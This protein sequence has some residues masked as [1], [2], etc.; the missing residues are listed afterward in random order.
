MN[1]EKEICITIET[2]AIGDI[3]TTVPYYGD[4]KD[5]K[6]I[7]KIPN[8]QFAGTDYTNLDLSLVV[9][10]DIE[11]FEKLNQRSDKNH[12]VY[13]DT[14]CIYGIKISGNYIRIQ[15][16]FHQDNNIKSHRM[17]AGVLTHCSERGN[18]LKPD[19]CVIPEC[20]SQDVC[21]YW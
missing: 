20:Y 21:V 7:L 8:R 9:E 3:I 5:N 13:I 11:N 19:I 1:K 6:F 16:W 12:Q 17:C 2:P 18:F 4:S 14:L 10:Y 15:Y